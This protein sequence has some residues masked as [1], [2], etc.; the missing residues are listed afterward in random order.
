MQTGRILLLVACAVTVAA[1][2]LQVSGLADLA[3]GGNVGLDGTVADGSGGSG[4]S[5]GSVG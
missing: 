2:G 5:S 4:S 3:D 1:C